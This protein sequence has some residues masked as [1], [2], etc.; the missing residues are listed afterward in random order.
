MPSPKLQFSLEE[1]QSVLQKTILSADDTVFFKDWIK[2]NHVQDETRLGIYID[3]YALRLIEALKTNYPAVHQLLGDDEF[4]VMARTYLDCYPPEHASIRWFGN[5]LTDFL[6]AQKPYSDQP[7]FSEL[8]QFEWALRHTIDAADA[9]VLSVENLQTIPPDRWGELCFE[10]H[11]SLTILNLSW[12]T[13]QVWQAL[14]N[15]ENLPEPQ[16]QSM[17][18][19]I[20]RQPDLI[21]AWRSSSEAEVSSLHLI[22]AGKTFADICEHL[23][24]YSDD[25]QQVPL[26]AAGF[27]RGWTEQGLLASPLK[28]VILSEAKDLVSKGKDSS[29]CSE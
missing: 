8:A 9:E 10:L 16:L 21:S 28:A 25:V 27:L 11:P 19:M 12:N 18:W 23:A 14:T 15:D 22:Q 29:L 17:A 1:W 26:I 4:D 7:V 6:A 5:H 20:Y 3:A 13:P 2:H 24:Q